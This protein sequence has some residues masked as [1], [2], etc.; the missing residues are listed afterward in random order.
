MLLLGKV[1]LQSAVLWAVLFRLLD[2]GFGGVLRFSRV[3]DL[4]EGTCL[5]SELVALAC[6]FE[7]PR[8]MLS[9]RR[10]GCLRRLPL[11]VHV[12]E[13]KCP[14]AVSKLITESVELFSEVVQRSTLI[15]AIEL[16]YSDRPVNGKL[17]VVLARWFRQRVWQGSR[18]R[19]KLRIESH[20]VDARRV[21]LDRG[22]VHRVY[23]F[24]G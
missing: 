17:F 22:L 15:T 6:K 2:I 1:I 8:L 23:L 7:Q 18:F 11:P 13:V 16:T 14:S 19:R 10:L 9:Q 24:V 5:F 21:A 3:V 20:G 12:S 4:R